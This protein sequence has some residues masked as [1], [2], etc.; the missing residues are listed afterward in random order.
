MVLKET[1]IELPPGFQDRTSW[2][3]RL[4]AFWFS[5]SFK[6][7][8]ILLVLLP[9]QV[10]AVVPGGEKNTWWGFVFMI[11]AIEA[12]IGPA[13]CGYLSDRCGSR[14]GRRKPFIAIGAAMT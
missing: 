11:G 13:I 10:A 8:I 3:L 12:M 4:S 14:F 7:F 1:P 6:W 9:M 2:Y 5:T